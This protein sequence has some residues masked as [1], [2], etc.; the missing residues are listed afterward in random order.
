MPNY[1]EEG[2]FTDDPVVA[3][4][5]LGEMI[6]R[7]DW[8]DAPEIWSAPERLTEV[9]KD[10]YCIPWELVKTA[11][12]PV[13]DEPVFWFDDRHTGITPA[14]YDWSYSPY[15]HS[16]T[17]TDAIVGYVILSANPITTG[18]TVG[19]LRELLAAIERRG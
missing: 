12:A 1:D 9:Y 10:R 6:R 16:N 4:M 2:Y 7:Y 5:F 11:I 13:E 15:Y 18:K 3:A 8:S 14:M 17:G 19:E